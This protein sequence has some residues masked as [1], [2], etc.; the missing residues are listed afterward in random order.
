MTEL[1]FVPQ[2][3]YEALL[4]SPNPANVRLTLA[5][6]QPVMSSTVNLASQVIMTPYMGSRIPF[7][8]PVQGVWRSEVFTEVPFQLTLGTGPQQVT[9]NSNYD[10]YAWMT[11]GRVTPAISPAWASDTSLGTNPGSAERIGLGGILLNRWDIP[12]G[13]TAMRGTYLGSFRTGTSAAVDWQ[14]GTAAGNWGQAIHNLYNYFNRKQV[15][16]TIAD[17]T[18]TWSWSS[19]AYRP[20]GGN[21]TSARVNML[22]GVSED[23]VFAQY[24]IRAQSA[25]SGT[26]PVVGI[27]LDQF[28]SNSAGQQGS[29]LTVG[30]TGSAFGFP[31]SATF[32]ALIPAGFHFLEPIESVAG[33]TNTS[34]TFVGN[35]TSQAGMTYQ[36]VM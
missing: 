29:G 11:G 1:T 20:A 23:P 27:G 6:G 24:V 7:Y 36:M 5:L 30:S 34:V 17:T 31:A 13:P 12:G 32:N 3:P 28:T 26:V 22:L 14:Y 33:P 10:F 2:S 16:G 35:I 15:S 8:A 19:A 18:A 4:Q 25:V 21:S 9:T